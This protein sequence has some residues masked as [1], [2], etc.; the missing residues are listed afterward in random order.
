MITHI[1]LIEPLPTG[2][3]RDLAFQFQS[4]DG[5]A[6]GALGNTPRSLRALMTCTTS[7][8]MHPA[9]SPAAALNAAGWG[10]Q[11]RR[12][13]WQGEKSS[14][15]R[16]C[17]HRS[18]AARTPE[19]WQS[20]EKSQSVLKFGPFPKSRVP[21]QLAHA[22]CRAAPLAQVSQEM[23]NCSCSCLPSSWHSHG[24][25]CWELSGMF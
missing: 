12:R 3:A 13:L 18:A 2:G 8:S 6:G 10:V 17:G 1:L 16:V 11:A 22:N 14:Q 19:R 9:C 25:G 21:V 7:V 5:S 4:L 20:N 24:R 23:I 15:Q